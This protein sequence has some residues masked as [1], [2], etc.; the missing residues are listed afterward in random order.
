MRK[1]IMLLA[2][3]SVLAFTTNAEAAVGLKLGV[4]SSNLT[5][6][7][8]PTDADP[9]PGIFA[10]LR[11]PAEKLELELM[12]SQQGIRDEALD[13]TWAIDYAQASVLL[14]VGDGGFF[15]GGY[16]ASLISA[17]YSEPGFSVDL[18][19]S[20]FI[21]DTDT[22]IIVGVSVGSGNT[23]LELRYQMSLDTI[24]P[25]VDIDVKNTMAAA[26][27]SFTF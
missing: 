18:T 17:E 16:S 11:I 8:A 12:M 7:D 15:V 4:S 13:A 6:D 1:I 21:N 10:G 14:F 22:G 9:R 23:N 27:L 3:A 20:N 26:T 25:D 2:V 19:D 24:D 5:G